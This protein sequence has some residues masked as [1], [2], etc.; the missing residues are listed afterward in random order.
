MC[1]QPMPRTPSPRTFD[2]ASFAAQ[3]PAIVSARPRTYRC[4]GGVST[5]F[6]NRSPN[7]ASVARIRSTRTMSIPSSVVPS[8]TSPRGIWTSTSG[9]ATALLHRDRLGEVARLVDVGAAGDRD[10]IREELER[11]DGEHGAERLVRIRD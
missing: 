11:D 4:S 5:R 6:E 8:G 2:T 10:V 7:F 1:R 9:A 3:R